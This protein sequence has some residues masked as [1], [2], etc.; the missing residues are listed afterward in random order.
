M[1]ALLQRAGTL[2]ASWCLLSVARLREVRCRHTQQSD[3]EGTEST[4]WSRKSH[5]FD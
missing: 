3:N 2:E 1:D 5:L 4:H